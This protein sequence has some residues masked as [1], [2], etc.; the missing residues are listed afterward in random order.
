MPLGKP[1]EFDS[2]DTVPRGVINAIKRDA[3]EC[4]MEQTTGVGSRYAISDTRDSVGSTLQPIFHVP[5]AQPM[6]SA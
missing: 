5:A 6:L 2:L 1:V 4:N 3:P